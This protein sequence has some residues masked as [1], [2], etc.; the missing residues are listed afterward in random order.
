MTTTPTPPVAASDHESAL[1]ERSANLDGLRD[2]VRAALL[3]QHLYPDTVSGGAKGTRF[4]LGV[5]EGRIVAYTEVLAALH[6]DYAALDAPAV[7][8]VLLGEALTEH[9]ARR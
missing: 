6:D 3:D 8:I 4:D 2:D 9:G 5:R 1:A 7:R